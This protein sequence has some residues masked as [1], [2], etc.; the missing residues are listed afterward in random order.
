[1]AFRLFQLGDGFIMCS[2]INLRHTSLAWFTNRIFRE[3]DKR[4]EACSS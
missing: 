4:A 3:W 1:M 2:F